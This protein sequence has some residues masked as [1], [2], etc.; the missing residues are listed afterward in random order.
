MIIKKPQ[1]Q[2]TEHQKRQLAK[3]SQHIP[4]RDA[5]LEVSASRRMLMIAIEKLRNAHDLLSQHEYLD[6]DM[7]EYL[8]ALQTLS[9]NVRSSEEQLKMHINKTRPK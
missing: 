2:F 3:I 8:I 4:L 9:E 1:S 5:L 7:A 6:L